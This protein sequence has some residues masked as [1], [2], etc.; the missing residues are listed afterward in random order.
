MQCAAWKEEVQNLVIFAGLFSSVLSAFV[1]QTYQSLQPDP[2]NQ[3]VFLLSQIANNMGSS[4]SNTSFTTASSFTPDS[5]SVRI[6]VL[7]LI[8]L[9]LSLTTVLIAIVASQWL[10]EHQHYPSSMSLMEKYALFHMRQESLAKWRVP[11]ILSSV[12]L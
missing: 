5:S 4:P 7:W 3:V 6:N 1:V 11:E 8:S 2:N 10:T 9:V 12:P